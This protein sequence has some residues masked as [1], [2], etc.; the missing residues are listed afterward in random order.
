M[1]LRLT[2]AVLTLC[3]MLAVM[4]LFERPACAYV[5]P[6]SGILACQAMSAFVAGAIFYFRQRVKQ[7]LGPF[8]K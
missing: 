1:K 4:N 6:G 5:D 2:F 8:K 3:L 7:L